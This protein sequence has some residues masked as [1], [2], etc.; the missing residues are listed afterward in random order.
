MTMLDPDVLIEK[1]Q[2]FVRTDDL[3]GDGWQVGFRR[4]LSA[5]ETEAN[6]RP[7]RVEQA[8]REMI[9]LLVTRARLATLLRERPEIA[10]LEVPAPLVITGLPRSGTTFLHHRCAELPGNR[11]YRL[12]E[13]RAPAFARGAPVDQAQREVTATTEALAW[14]YDH[15]PRLR[16]IHPIEANLPDECNWLLRPTFA[17]PVFAW[18]N[19]VPSYD[20]YLAEADLVPAY[21]EWWL[22]LQAIRWRSPGGMP[23]LKDPGHLWALDAL[24]EVQPNTRVVVLVRDLAESVASLC[25]LCATLQEMEADPPDRAAIGRYVLGMVE[26]GLANLSRARERMPERFSLVPYA[27]LIADPI[28][29]LRRIQQWCDRPFDAV[30]EQRLAAAL[31]AQARQARTPHVYSLAEYG[32]TV[33]D[34]PA[35]IGV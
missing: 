25:S 22:Q 21:R 31:R 13:L 16:V 10:E 11:G 23:V 29:V 17:T 27:E 12:W 14:L 3:L 5:I 8:A 34:L 18:A 7:R 1:A 28:G 24:L 6:P 20:R 32:L 2:Q 30:A 19:Y 35:A 9:G 4:L 15:A 33:D 26:R